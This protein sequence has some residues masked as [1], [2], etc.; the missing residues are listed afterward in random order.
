MASDEEYEAFYESLGRHYPESQIV[1][2]EA[3]GRTRRIVVRSYLRR[4]AA[5]GL[6]LFDVGC[7]A[8]DYSLFYA[9]LGQPAHG[10]DISASLIEEAKAKAE[11]SGLSKATFE[12]ANA[13]TYMGAPRDAVLFSEVLE[14]VRRPQA[15]LKSILR[16]L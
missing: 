3:L 15:A 10:I 4:F 5:H 11:R 12:V 8:G 9:S 7:N 6:T 2:Q 13:E 14:H 1:Y 16:S